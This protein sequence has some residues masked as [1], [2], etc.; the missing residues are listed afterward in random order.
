MARTALLSI[1]LF[2]GA[3]SL[4]AAFTPL[5]ALPKFAA[6]RRRST[7]L[8]CAAKNGQASPV[9]HMPRRAFATL[10]GTAFLAFSGAGDVAFSPIKAAAAVH[11]PETV[12]VV[13]GKG[14]V[15]TQVLTQLLQQGKKVRALTRNPTE[16]LPLDDLPPAW[17]D[18]EWVSGDL[19]DPASISP[20]IVSGVSHII[21]CPG[22]QGYKDSDNSRRVYEEG[23]AFLLSLSKDHSDALKRVVYFSS[24]GT[25]PPL[26]GFPLAGLLRSA[27]KYKRRGEGVVRHSG[28]E[29]SIVRA[30]GL[31]SGFYISR[32][33]AEPVEGAPVKLTEYQILHRPKAGPVYA[34]TESAPGKGPPAPPLPEIAAAMAMARTLSL[35]RTS[36]ANALS[37]SMLDLPL[38]PAVKVEGADAPVLGGA[39]AVPVIALD[40]TD[41]GATMP[42]IFLEDIASV[43]I[44]AAYESKAAGKTL[45][46]VE[47]PASP[48]RSPSSWHSDFAAI[49]SDGGARVW[50]EDLIDA[51]RPARPRAGL[52][53]MNGSKRLAL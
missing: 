3:L 32:H 18:I 1:A 45:F 7:D 40:S 5:S 50:E 10:A 38:F 26:D 9:S 43:I 47:R 24:D 41:K 11:E 2:L 53:P 19:N 30:K 6:A 4:A 28:V 36:P 21:Y 37:S 8:Q 31:S 34:Q 33:T 35:A 25:D 44:A 14:M 51:P 13:G 12:L 20:A 42:G 52:A 48:S 15:G 49:P 46:A 39:E 22:A 17:K 29:Y 16:V 27:A 23:V